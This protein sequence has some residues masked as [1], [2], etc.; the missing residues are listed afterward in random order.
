MDERP[1]R[2]LGSVVLRYVALSAVV[3]AAATTLQSPLP[4]P[5]IGP[6]AALVAVGSMLWWERRHHR[7]ELESRRRIHNLE[8]EQAGLMSREMLHTALLSSLPVGVIAMRSGRP[9]YA[10]RAAIE[11]LGE[12]ITE[13]GAPIPTAVRQVIVDASAGRSSSGHFSQGFPRRVM[14][15]SGHPPGRDGVMLLHLLDVT[16]RWQA[17]RMR[18][19]FVLAASHELKT[20]VAAIQAAAETV[21]VALDDEPDV[22]REFSGRILDNAMRMSRIVTDLLDLS[23]LESDTPRVEPFDLADVLGEEVRRFGSSLPAVQFEAVPTP[24]VG[25]PSDLALAFRNL[26]ENAV[27]HTPEHGQ[28]ST[29]VGSADGEAL[30]VVADSGSGIPAADI[31]RIFER[32]YRV[33]AARSRAT[34]GTGLGLAIVKHVAELH[35]GRVE[36]ESRLGEGSTFRLR[37]P[38][39]PPKT[40]S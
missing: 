12:R 16:D 19:D 37:V 10:N 23:R 31:P 3:V 9:V 28:V 29:W 4:W 13:V 27:R 30:V 5:W 40:S 34:G 22:V 25:N 14:E 38:I 24:I 15:V 11:F 6:S 8:A 7:S 1:V 35:G 36:V 33:D 18:Q 2:R 21:L 20:P 26:V 32:F 39:L 17:D